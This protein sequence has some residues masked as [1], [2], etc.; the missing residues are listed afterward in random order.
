[1]ISRLYNQNNYQRQLIS[2]TYD[3]CTTGGLT[4]DYNFTGSGADSIY[5]DLGDGT[6]Y[7]D[8]TSFSYTY[9]SN[10]TYYVEMIASEFACGTSV[11]IRDTIDF[12][13][14]YTAVTAVVPDSINNCDGNLTVNFSSGNP[15]PPQNTWDLPHLIF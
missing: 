3:P 12:N 4:V 13:P 2:P 1:M 14:L 11:T 10:G 6:T 9:N 5:W 7:I 8:S 15:A